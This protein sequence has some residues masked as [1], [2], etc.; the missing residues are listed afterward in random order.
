[1]KNLQRAC[2]TTAMSVIVK[3]GILNR[4]RKMN[5][6]SWNCYCVPIQVKSL[7]SA[8]D[9]SAMSMIVKFVILMRMRHMHETS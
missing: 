6:T 9:T 3:F 5:E 1:M 8:Y 2:D 4:M 7:L